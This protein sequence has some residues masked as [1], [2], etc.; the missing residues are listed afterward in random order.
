MRHV[1][2]LPAQH[3]ACPAQLRVVQLRQAQHFQHIAHRRERAAQL[4]CQRGEEFVLAPVGGRQ[5][6][7]E[8]AGLLA[9]QLQLLLVFAPVAGDKDGDLVI[10]HALVHAPHG[11]EQHGN[12]LPLALAHVEQDFRH[13]ALHLHQ[14]QPVRLVEHAPADGQQVLQ[15]LFP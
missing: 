8:L 1:A 7:V 3:V 15:F 14:R 10:T 4:V 6:L 12:R 9:R 13:A 2:Y 11:I 5:L